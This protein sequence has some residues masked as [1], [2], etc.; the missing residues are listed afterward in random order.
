MRRLF[1]LA[2]IGAVV[3]YFLNRRSSEPVEG[4]TIGYADGSAVT[5]DGDAPEL[6]RLVEVAA[7]ASSR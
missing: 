1:W 7:A 6:A 4:A 3:W 2:L 5:L